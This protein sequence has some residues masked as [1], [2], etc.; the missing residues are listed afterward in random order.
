[1]AMSLKSTDSHDPDWIGYLKY[2]G[3]GIERGVMGARTSAHALYGFDAALRHFLSQEAPALRDVEFE[4]PVLVRPGSWEALIPLTAGAWIKT[5][6]GAATVAYGGAAA[7]KMADNDF[8]DIGLGVIFKKSLL[9]LQSVVSLAKH[10]GTLRTKQFPKVKWDQDKE[11]IG[12]PNEK[13]KHLFVRKSTLDLFVGCPPGLFADMAAVIQH[14]REL[15]IGVASDGETSSIRIEESERHI[16]YIPD[17]ENEPLFPELQH[18][19]DVE[20]DGIVTRGNETSNSIGFQYQGH[21]LACYPQSGSIVRFK[22]AL[23]LKCRIRG[24]INRADDL[25]GMTSPRPKI[26]F[27]SLTKLE[28]DATTP[29]LFPDAE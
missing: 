17:S 2:S 16:F 15:E 6:L 10:L 25:G 14:D 12:I 4:I 29:E 22:S 3:P 8:K 23:F 19:Q 7:K 11:R 27:E 20:L 1:M 9:G 5:A 18:G 24:V 26:F 28:N 13:G 21:I